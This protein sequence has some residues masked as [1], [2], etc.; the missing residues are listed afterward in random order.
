MNN[1]LRLQREYVA[2]EAF[3][4]SDVS[5]VLKKI[6]P[7][8]TE[9]ITGF[10]G[11]FTND[12]P[13]MSLASEQSYMLREIPKH[14][15]V[16]LMDLTAYKPQGLEVDLVEYVDNLE[17]AVSHAT[18]TFHKL[19]P[20][21]TLM[22]SRLISQEDYQM[23][24]ASMV[25]QYKDLDK[26]REIMNKDIGGCFKKG[27]TEAQ[28]TYG[29]LVKRNADWK[30]I[31]ERVEKMTIAMNGV[32]RK[33]L[34]KKVEETV[35]LLSVLANKIERGELAKI[36]PQLVE[37]ISEGAYQLGSE[38]EFFSVTYYRL[39]ELTGTMN[40]TIAHFK[41]AVTA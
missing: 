28:T 33:V 22:L 29:K 35:E 27:S 21:F 30:E 12:Q 41:T 31:F 16:D 32:D 39:M 8:V 1:Q 38:L 2:L 25:K 37:G 15:Y 9:S 34:N 40:K 13:A 10:V 11:R 26:Q 36:S 19:L 5:S 7:A 6:F 14:T 24:S 3:K 17:V 4:I 20:E 23:N 18:E